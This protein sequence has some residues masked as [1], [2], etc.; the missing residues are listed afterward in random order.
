MQHK[1]EFNV[2]NYAVSCS[3]QFGRKGKR[4]VTF[5]PFVFIHSSR[6]L[7]DVL[8]HIQNISCHTDI[9]SDILCAG[10]F[11]SSSLSSMYALDVCVS[12]LLATNSREFLNSDTLSS[13]CVC[14][15]VQQTGNR[16]D[17]HSNWTLTLTGNSNENYSNRIDLH[18]FISLSSFSSSEWYC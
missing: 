2:S 6:Y 4:T 16:N 18:G 10:F 11:M 5:T 14:V 7:F 1:N 9:V 15:C 17:T 12:A 8:Y 3:L 13:V